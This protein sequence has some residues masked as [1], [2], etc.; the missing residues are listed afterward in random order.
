MTPFKVIFF[1]SDGF[2]AVGSYSPNNA[3][4]EVYDFGTG[5]WTTVQDYPY[6]DGYIYIYNLIYVPATSAYYVI[7]GSGGGARST[8]GKFK[9]GAWSEAGQLNAP[10]YVSF[11]SFFI[12]K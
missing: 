1:I 3:K 6:G 7:G 9:N 2:L 11:Y 10:R 12:F 4:A 5:V 8:I